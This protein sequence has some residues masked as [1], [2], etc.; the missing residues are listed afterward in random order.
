MTWDEIQSNW[1]A[2]SDVIKLTWG[3]LSEEDLTAVAGCRDQLAET[4]QQLYGYESV[5]AQEKVDRFAL[6]LNLAPG[7]SKAIHRLN[8]TVH[9]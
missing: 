1:K 5:D 4:L 3:K 7:D 8:Q 6:E 9:H 2:V